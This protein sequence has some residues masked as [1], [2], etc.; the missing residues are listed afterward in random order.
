[1]SIL[2]NDCTSDNSYRSY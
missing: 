1:V 2:W